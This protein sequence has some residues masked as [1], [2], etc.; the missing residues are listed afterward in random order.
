MAR[1]HD[2]ERRYLTQWVK[3]PELT[4]YPDNVIGGYAAIFGKKSTPMG[5]YVEVIEPSFFRKHLSD[6]AD[7][8]CSYNFSDMASLGAVRS[9]TL[10]LNA[11]RVGLAFVVSLPSCRSDVYEYADRGDVYN[12]AID[13]EVFEDRW[14]MRDDR[15]PVRH[16]LS[17]KLIELSIVVAEHP[18]MINT[19][20]A[21]RSLAAHTGEPLDMITD[22]SR[23]DE[24]RKLWRDPILLG[25]NGREAHI[26]TMAPD[27]EVPR[28]LDSYAVT[29]TPADLVK[30]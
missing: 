12:T 3:R 17:G 24:L 14:N 7:T 10:R 23:R 18:D 25:R 2:H 4:T 29:A 30:G 1:A 20:V 21:L 13:V 9:D 28:I 26:E 27:S 11:T 5:G 22:L 6:N 19:D 15:Y 16:L 8:L